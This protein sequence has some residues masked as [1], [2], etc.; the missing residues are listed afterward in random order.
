[1]KLGIKYYLYFIPTFVLFFIASSVLNFSTSEYVCFFTAISFAGLYCH[2]NCEQY[3]LARTSRF[4]FANALMSFYR[5]LE[6]YI[7]DTTWGNVILRHLPGFIFFLLM[8]LIAGFDG[9]DSLVYLI[10]VLLFEVTYFFFSKNVEKQI[11]QD[12]L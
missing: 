2:P 11:D 3:F 4:N 5:I 7:P 9:R 10:G 12:D 1:M 6:K 8:S